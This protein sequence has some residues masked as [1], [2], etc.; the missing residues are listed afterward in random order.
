MTS[1]KTFTVPVGTPLSTGIELE[2]LIAYLNPTDPDPD[3]AISSTLP[4]I[5]RIDPVQAMNGDEEKNVLEATYEAIGEHIRTTFRSHGLCINGPRADPDADESIPAHLDQWDLTQ[6]GSVTEE[7]DYTTG[8]IGRYQWFSAEFRSPAFWDV[9][10]AYEEMSVAVNV[11]AS[12]YRVRVNPTCGFHVHVGNGPRYFPAETVKRAGAFLFAADPMLSRLHAPWRRVADYSTSIRYESRLA[13]R[14]GMGLADAQEILDDYKVSDPIRVVPWSDRTREAEEF[15]GMAKWEA[16]AKARVRD[17][18]YMTLSERPPSPQRSPPS[19]VSEESVSSQLTLRGG[20]GST[21]PPS[22]QFSQ[23]SEVSPSASPR[24]PIQRGSRPTS[25]RTRSVPSSPSTSEGSEDRGYYPRLLALVEKARF[26]TLCLRA[27]GHDNPRSLTE[28]KLFGLIVMYRCQKLFGKTDIDKLSDQNVEKVKASC[29]PFRESVRML[30][31]WNTGDNAVRRSGPQV[32]PVLVHPRPHRYNVITAP[33]V[34]RRLSEQATETWEA[35]RALKD[36]KSSASSSSSSSSTLSYEPGETNAIE[37]FLYKNIDNLMEQPGFPLDKTETIMDL[38]K[39]RAMSSDGSSS[40]SSWTMSRRGS[41]SPRSPLQAFPSR[42]PSLDGSPGKSSSS[43]GTMSSDGRRGSASPRSPR[44]SYPSRRP[45]RDGPP[46]KS[47]SSHSSSSSVRSSSKPGS[48]HHSSSS[49]SEFVKDTGSNSDSSKFLSSPTS[50]RHRQPSIGSGGGDEQKLLPHSISQL[51]E[52][53]ISLVR[54]CMNRPPGADARFL[55][56]PWLPR[57]GGLGLGPLDPGEPHRRGS[58]ECGGEWCTEHPVTDTRAG[59][60]ALASVD[61]AGAAAAMLDQATAQ[62]LNYNFMAYEPGAR[63]AAENTK[64][65][66]EFREAGGS[67]DAEWVPLWAKVCVGI[68]K[69]SG[70]APVDYY[71]DVL[72]RVVSEEER[73]RGDDDDDGNGSERSVEIGLYDVCDLLEDMGLFAEARAIR[74]RERELGPP[75]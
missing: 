8:N 47:S 43:S 52:S 62:R 75:R 9:P 30:C 45:S 72:E 60:A 70:D 55:R 38:Y 5:L 54:P 7:H 63:P 28:E 27:Y 67:L 1:N 24:L 29:A 68:M 16:Y 56:I 12:S 31:R 25:P 33:T 34:L 71:L 61:S 74:R 14:E 15:E 21:A 10:Q 59:V 22:P 44:Q 65:T 40:S 58:S 17:G 50:S 66:I 26:Q 41:V 49:S 13:C 19:P 73:G 4:P 32:A 53:Y 3:E 37:P 42:R 64:R 18:P 23:G 69:F 57:P 11:L 46:G 6:D 39:T 35:E 48:S 36:S 2:M 20:G 51:P